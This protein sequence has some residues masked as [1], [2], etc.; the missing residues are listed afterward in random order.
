MNA[1]DEFLSNWEKFT[2][3]LKGRILAMST[4]KE[5]TFQVLSETI[6]YE[7]DFWTSRYEEGGR[8]IERFSKQNPEKGD[9]VRSI[10][11]HDLHFS[12]RVNPT[13]NI[14]MIR[15]LRILIGIVVGFLLI[16]LSPDSWIMKSEAFQNFQRL[17]PYVSAGCGGIVFYFMGLQ[18][19]TS[20][21]TKCRRELIEAYMRQLDKFKLS[22]EMV[23]SS[24][25]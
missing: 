20:L 7:R 15:I 9:I 22:V 12:G 11:T 17:M 5:L 10:L 18:F 21:S 14:G 23:F 2:A 6:D 8:W 24:S 1:K 19:D 25:D 13:S 16:K 3:K 4:Q